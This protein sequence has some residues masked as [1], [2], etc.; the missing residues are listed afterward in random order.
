MASVRRAHV[1][2]GGFPRGELGGHDMDY[3]RLRILELLEQKEVLASVGNDFHGVEQWLP[4]AQLLITYT[5][6]PFLDDEQ[7]RKVRSWIEEGGKW[8][9]LHGSSG[10]KAARIEGSRR[11]RMVKVDHH[12]TLGAFFISHPPIRKFQ[13]DLTDPGHPLMKDVPESFET[14]DEPYMIE[15]MHPDTQMLLTSKLGPD[16]RPDD[17]GFAYDEDTSLFPD[18][19]TRALG[20][21]RPL[22]RGGSTYIALGHAHSPQSNAQSAVDPSVAT[23]GASPGVLR[24]TWES[25]AYKQILRNAIDW[26]VGA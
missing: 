8:L 22:G 24:V 26:G 6:G 2:V 13:V 17:F 9:G 4:N 12:D 20:F 21:T 15:V 5:A 16:P 18:G 7:N 23:D 19:V 25:E 14:V 3:A 11:R 1:V 10:G